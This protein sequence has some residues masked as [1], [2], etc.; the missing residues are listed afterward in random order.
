MGISKNIAADLLRRRA[1]RL[2]LQADEIDPGGG[3]PEE[4][5]EQPNATPAGVFIVYNGAKKERSRRLVVVRR[6]WARASDR[7]FVRFAG[8][9]HL[10]VALRQFRTDRVDE[11]ICLAT[12]E[13]IAEPAD[14]LRSHSGFAIEDPVIDNT[15]RALAAVREELVLLGYLARAD[16]D[17]GLDELETMVDF[18]HEHAPVVPIDLAFVRQRLARLAPDGDEFEH[19]ARRVCRTQ[20]R[21]DRFVRAA[22]RTVAIDGS[23]DWTEQEA[24]REF[25]MIARQSGIAPRG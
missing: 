17:F 16:G 9:C 10:A 1:K 11:L 20:A 3:A 18:V 2:G 23:V 7:G 13:V 4:P 22:N 14:W 15:R 19:A 6:V 5:D 21:H 25:G 8:F 12:G 24:F